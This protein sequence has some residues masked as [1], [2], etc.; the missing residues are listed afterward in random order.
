M[1]A[2]E[3]A[4]R[5]G[6]PAIWAAILIVSCVTQ[7]YVAVADDARRGIVTP[8]AWSFAVQATSHIVIAA[9][10]PAVY[11]MQ[12]HFPLKTSRNIA[13]HVVGLVVF[14]IAHTLGM[15]ALRM[16]WF[17]AILGLPFHFPI[18]LG[19]LEY[20]FTKDIFTYG[21][22]NAGI[23]A[24]R[25]VRQREATPE[26]A[27][28]T[29][30]P[31][32][33]PPALATPERFAVRKRGGNEVMVEVADIDWIEASGNYA[34]LHVGGETFEIRSTLTKL[35]GELDPRRF[36]RVHKSH[37]V[38]IGRVAEVVPWVSGDWRIRL[39]DGAEVNLSRRYRQR[40]EALAPVKT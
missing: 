4:W 20:E 2:Q 1:T 29:E 18:T 11:W 3:R 34:I 37:V 9:L 28:P 27:A 21:M 10:I 19:R 22:M 8:F 6:V 7:A 5:W 14:S 32:E 16:L 31:V 13:I 23:M 24:I 36:V 39:Q 40:F 25:F 26:H 30:A 17:E 38:N 12:R 35:E 33:A 15:A